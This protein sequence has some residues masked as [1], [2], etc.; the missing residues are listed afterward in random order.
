MGGRGL[1]GA[2]ATFEGGAKGASAGLADELGPG[3]L[4]RGVLADAAGA[5]V[6]VVAPG[7]TLTCVTVLSAGF[8]GSGIGVVD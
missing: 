8:S 7:S 2:G 1:G 6:E 4:G 5:G 3:A